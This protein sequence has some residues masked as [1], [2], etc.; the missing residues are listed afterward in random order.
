MKLDKSGRYVMYLRKSRKDA[1]YNCD[2]D[3]LARHERLLRETV[4]RLGIAIGDIYREVR[5]GDS[6]SAR[7]MMQKLL[8]EVSDGQWDGVLVVEVERLARGDTI[9]Q[10]LVSRAFQESGTLIITPTKTYDPNNEFDEEYFEFG[11]FMSRREYKTIKRRLQRGRVAASKEGKYCGNVAPYGYRRERIRNDRGFQLVPDPDEAPVIRDIFNWYV[12]GIPGDDGIR[13]PAGT[14][15][16][17]DQ[18]NAVGARPRINERWS[19]CS[20]HDILKNPVYIGKIVWGKRHELDS[21]DENGAARPRQNHSV[22]DAG[23]Y[24]GLHE[25][26]IPEALYYAAQEKRHSSKQAHIHCKSEASNALTGL[27][28][29]QDCGRSLFYRKAG[30][31]S[32]HDTML[33][34]NRDCHNIG[35]FY[36][37]LE[38]RVIDAIRSCTDEQI[39]TDHAGS[40]QTA[41]LAAIQKKEKELAALSGQLENIYAAFERGVYSDDLFLSRSASVKKQA[42]A[43]KAALWELRR[44]LENQKSIERR[45]QEILPK[46]VH[47]VD[48]YWTIE[49]PA[50]RNALLKEVIDH[51]D[52][53]KHKKS[54]KGGPFDNFSLTIYP[55]IPCLEAIECES[56]PPMAGRTL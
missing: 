52:Y 53:E 17:A 27:I 38:E 48:V 2:E 40:Q 36:D 19:Y 4:K 30:A 49:S 14:V 31:R 39:C 56:A 11:L 12:N 3:I 20:I 13:I 28:R 50:E 51:I 43:A 34:G 41:L 54:P 21:I 44:R 33:C 47:L 46:M 16:I 55:K 9:D 45:Q 7:P 6:I 42:D 24:D 25:A 5:S 37:I 35:C 8:S 18:L 32:P 1:E 26:L 15:R 29:C 23:I 22:P 10:G